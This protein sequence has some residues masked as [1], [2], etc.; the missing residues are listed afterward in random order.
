MSGLDAQLAAYLGHRLP[1]AADIRIG[2]LGRIHGGSSQE[3]FRFTAQWREGGGEVE[4]RL[5]LR[6]A[7][8]AGLVVAE[9]DLEFNVYAALAGTSVP[10][11]G[12]HWLEL[13]P[14]WL[15]RPFFIMDL[16]PGKPGH[17]F[18]SEDP[19][20]GQGEAV[21]C[22][23][24]RALGD[25]AALDHAALGLQSLRGGQASGPFWQCELA[26]WEAILDAGE[27]GV[28]P[29]VRGA[30]RWLRRNPPPP[31]AKPAVVHGDYRSGNFLFLPDGTIGAVLDWEMCH[32]GDPLEDIA[33]AI[34]PMWTMER[35]FPLDRGLALW[36]QASGLVLDRQ[37]LD[38][39]RLFVAVKACAIWT[40]AEASFQDGKSREPIVALTALR[41]SHFHRKEILDYMASRGAM[42]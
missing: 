18:G 36:E 21:G 3:T 34:D 17:F 31:P 5:I 2:D 7:P 13:D 35:H 14:R 19:Y 33:W 29:I 23:F 22:N 4:K 10:V 8:E 25:L 20:E 15:E 40:T 37:A 39:W 16:A 28:E 12:V 9:R 1:D 27:D 24:W 11:P 32:I 41:A 26:H 6:R 38:W 42:G 30:I